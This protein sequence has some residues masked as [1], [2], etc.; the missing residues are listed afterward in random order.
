MY[1]YETPA[2][3]FADLRY[4]GV[5]DSVDVPQNVQSDSRTRLIQ[6][7]IQPGNSSPHL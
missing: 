4:H 1:T 7:D 2:A 6:I 3:N 5:L